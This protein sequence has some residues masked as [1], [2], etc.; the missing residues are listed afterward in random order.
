MNNMIRIKRALLPVLLL[1][2]LAA[3][4]QTESEILAEIETNNTTLRALRQEIE[5]RRLGNRTGIFLPDPEAQFNYLWG[6]PSLLGNRVNI[7]V[8]QSFDFP[9]AYVHRR[10]ISRV[11]NDQL[12][13]E[14]ERNLK[15]IL[16]RAR[17]IMTDIAY[18]NSMQ[19]EYRRRL[20]HAEELAASFEA[21]LE[22][23]EAGLPDYNK[24]HLN[25]LN[26]EKE[27][28][29]SGIER[30]MLLSELATLNGG[31]YVDVTK[32]GYGSRPIP[33]DFSSWYAEAERENPVLEWLA[34]ETEISRR[35]ESLSTALG[36]PRMH[37]GYMSETI[38]AEGFRGIAAG[39]T[40]PLWENKNRVRQAEAN[41]LA[42]REIESDNKLRFFYH[43]QAQFEKAAA[44]QKSIE[45]YRQS[46]L[47]LDNTEMLKMALD[48]GEISLAEYILELTIYYDSID[49]LLEAEREMRVAV[50]ELYMFH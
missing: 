39:L 35:Q 25:L 36:L 23:G 19:M 29:L 4:A 18:Y 7:A 3:M 11:R 41:T 16:Y 44:L 26:T 28:E 21:R 24:A 30:E 50:E 14:Y 17:L 1:A 33:D 13:I 20:D 10:Q 45:D 6:D 43:L 15:A 27:S 32:I 12:E 22:Q 31:K 49:R 47:H 48:L 38:G 9:S 46:L 34:M 8:T 42:M 2:G 40:I 37:A 5:A